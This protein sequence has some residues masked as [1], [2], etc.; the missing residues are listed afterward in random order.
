MGHAEKAPKRR[1]ADAV[2]TAGTGDTRGRA[3][4]GPKPPWPCPAVRLAWAWSHL[5]VPPP[6]VQ[7]RGGASK[8]D[9]SCRSPSTCRPQCGPCWRGGLVSRVGAA[10]VP[11]STTAHLDELAPLSSS[12]SAK[13]VC[14]EI[15]SLRLI[16]LQTTNKERIVRRKIS[17]AVQAPPVRR[18]K[19]VIATRDAND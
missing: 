3:V 5:A 15:A 13:D 12:P 18:K 1:V 8:G 14:E 4:R 17:N 11:Q 19:K 9:D 7:G 2:Q 6:T 10:P 16:R